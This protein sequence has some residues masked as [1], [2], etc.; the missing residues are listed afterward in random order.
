MQPLVELL[1]ERFGGLWFSLYDERPG[2]L[3]PGVDQQLAILLA[4]GGGPCRELAVTPM[5]HWSTRPHD[6]RR[7]L[8]T[9]LAYQPLPPDL[10][11]AGVIPKLGSPLELELLAKLANVARLEWRAASQ[12]ATAADGAETVYYRNAGG[13][14]WRLVKSFPTRYQSERG[15]TRT[16]TEMTLS[17]RPGLPPVMI[18]CFSS[19]LFYWYWRVASNCRHLTERELSAFPIPPSLAEPAALEVLR[20]LCRRYERCL[21]QTMSRKAT[22]NANSGRIVQDEYRVAAAKPILD[23]IDR[24]LAPHYGLSAAELDFVIN[25]DL[26]YRMAGRR[27]SAK[28]RP[29]PATSPR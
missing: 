24:A 28:V 21:K 10:R 19:S 1:Q 20:T 22:N 27:S 3:F 17:V 11:T 29:A 14:Y 13:R 2:K 12:L 25:Y 5:R 4:H 16:S 9:T 26:K 23:E 6:E 7:R 15:T 18:A 8:F